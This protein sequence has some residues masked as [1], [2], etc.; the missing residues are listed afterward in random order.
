MAGE[1]PV[2]YTSVRKQNREGIVRIAGSAVLSAI[3]TLIAVPDPAAAQGCTM[4][5]VAAEMDGRGRLR[6]DCVLQ[7]MQA[8]FDQ[9]IINWLSPVWYHLRTK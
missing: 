9:R 3:I 5:P 7:T 4:P 8:N 1:R 2:R 6:R